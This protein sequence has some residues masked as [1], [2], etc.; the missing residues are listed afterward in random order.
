VNP[1][2]RADLW[3][4]SAGAVA[5]QGV[6]AVAAPACGAA[7]QGAAEQSGVGVAAR[8]GGSRGVLGGFKGGARDLG[9]ARSRRKPARSRAGIAASVACARR[10]EGDDPVE[11][12]RA[13]SEKGRALC[14]RW[15]VGSG[16]KGGA[17][18]AA[19][20]GA[21]RGGWRAAAGLRRWRERARWAEVRAGVAGPAE[22]E[23]GLGWEV[24][25]WVRLGLVV[26]L[27][28]LFLSKF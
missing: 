15:Q 8:V 21:G 18:Q 23:V 1:G 7:E 6:V 10:G 4:G 17:T 14:G 3:W 5:R 11:W 28:F 2:L 25:V 27:F 24:G 13:V 19:W 22:R 12:V 26:G 9:R 20:R 16:A